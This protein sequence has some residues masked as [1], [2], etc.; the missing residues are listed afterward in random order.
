MKVPQLANMFWLAVAGE[1]Y[2]GTA[3]GLGGM[4][5]GAG[6]GADTPGEGVQL[7]RH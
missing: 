1:V 2:P 3:S 5:G 6:G 7:P 4:W